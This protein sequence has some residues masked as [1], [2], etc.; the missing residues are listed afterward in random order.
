MGV[1]AIRTCVCIILAGFKLK[2][3]K[4]KKISFLILF[5]LFINNSYA[6]D[7]IF[8]NSQQKPKEEYKY[9]KC[10]DTVTNYREKLTYDEICRYGAGCPFENED[11]KTIVYCTDQNLSE[12]FENKSWKTPNQLVGVDS[13]VKIGL[14]TQGL[15]FKSGVKAGQTCAYYD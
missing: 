8:K 4:M 9:Y 11:G 7:M 6:V 10:V 15:S 2:G 13:R 3:F 14:V 5:F 1:N 12:C